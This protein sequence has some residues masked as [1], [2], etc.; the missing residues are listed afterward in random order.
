MYKSFFWISYIQ[1]FGLFVRIVRYGKKQ[2]ENNSYNKNG[3]CMSRLRTSIL[4]RLLNTFNTIGDNS[5]CHQIPERC[6]CIKGYI[7]PIC[8]RCTGVLI[9]QIISVVLIFF[10]ITVSPV[11][12][13]TL[14]GIMGADW[15][16]QKIGIIMSTNKRRFIT[17][18]L[19]GF[20]L[21]E[22]Y[23][24]IVVYAMKFLSTYVM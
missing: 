11:Y 10:K 17:G 21:F 7:F 15:F 20:G 4:E 23:K 5:G 18:I 16:I 13:V 19:G 8:A 9:G 3:E 24:N 12:A 1:C 6:F 14:L 22:I 2:I